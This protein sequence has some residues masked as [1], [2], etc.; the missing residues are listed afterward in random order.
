MRGIRR[1]S[2]YELGDAETDECV[3]RSK[4][5]AFLLLNTYL[6][7]EL[8]IVTRKQIGQQNGCDVIFCK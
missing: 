2:K 8:L 1:N 4:K 7:L 3:G 5:N 6:F